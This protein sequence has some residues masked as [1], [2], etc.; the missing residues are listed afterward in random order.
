[1]SVYKPKGR[2]QLYHYDFWIKPPG[3][4]ST[5]FYGSTGQKE[6]AAAKRVENRYR[7]LAVTGRLTSDMTLNMAADRY[8]DEIAIHQSSADDTAKSLEHLCRLFGAETLLVDITPS[9]V[10]DVV[11]RRSA[12]EVIRRRDGTGTGK[13][14]SNAT[15]N[16]QIVEPLQRVLRRARRVWGV[17]VDTDQFAWNE[18]KLPEPAGRTREFTGDELD[19]FWS[20]LRPDYHPI[21]WFC[22]SKGLRKTACVGM[23]K[24]R[25]DI[26]KLAIVVQRKTKK[27]GREW[28]R[29]GIT[30][31]LAALLQ[32]E[33]ALAPGDAVWSYVVQRGDDAGIRQAITASGLRRAM[34]SALKAAGIEDFRI[35]DLRHDFASKLL[36][37]TRNLAIVQKALDHADITSTVRY[38]HVLDEDVVKGLEELEQSRSYPGA[39]AGPNVREGRKRR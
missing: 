1:M 5:R 24:S 9:E 30:P 4:K 18:H 36:R 29:Q 23:T 33:M 32:R 13:L 17:P 11:R 21:V 12:E 39:T 26:D 3:G 8:Y 19:R 27:Q 14:V 22:L 2:T 38:A 16:R 25:V 34:G 37:R 10:A 35:H 15:V 7:E 28:A 6:K 20:A 31:A